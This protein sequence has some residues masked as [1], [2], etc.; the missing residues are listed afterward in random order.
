MMRMIGRIRF[1]CDAAGGCA[2]GCV[3]L[4]ATVCVVSAGGGA[5]VV[6]AGGGTV[7]VAAA[8]D[9]VDAA[10]CGAGAGG[11]TDV[12]DTGATFGG[13]AS[14]AFSTRLCTGARFDFFFVVDGCAACVRAG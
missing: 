9:L 7:W 13:G 11:A 12:F 1:V 2:A 4:L 6:V 5:V 8:E 3:E 10:C 14:S